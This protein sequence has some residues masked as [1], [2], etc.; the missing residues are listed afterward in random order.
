MPAPPGKDAGRVLCRWHS[1]DRGRRLAVIGAPEF[2]WNVARSL[3][4]L[5]IVVRAPWMSRRRTKRWY[6]SAK[7]SEMTSMITATALA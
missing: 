1:P 4:Y 6:A 7:A 5:P 3:T 2:R